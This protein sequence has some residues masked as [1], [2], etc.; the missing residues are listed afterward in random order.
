MTLTEHGR[1]YLVR[2]GVPPETVIKTGSSMQEVLKHYADKINKSSVLDR[3]GFKTKKYFVVSAHREENVDQEEKLIGFLHFLALLEN[4]MNCPILVSTHPRTQKRIEALTEKS[5]GGIDW[6]NLSKNI[7]FSKPLAFSDYIQLQ[8]NAVCVISD[9]GTIMEESA[10][11]GFPAVMARDAH[12]RPEGMDSGVLIMAS[13]NPQ[14]LLRA[15]EI[16]LAQTQ[17]FSH[18]RVPDYEQ[19]HVSKKVLRIILSYKDYI[20]RT[21]WHESKK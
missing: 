8:R 15:V 12:E 17:T 10:L 16:T 19:D 20:K 4:K 6:K 2:E 13:M 1:R 5:V 11:L 7:H 21:V 18:P 3:L 9:S 14:D